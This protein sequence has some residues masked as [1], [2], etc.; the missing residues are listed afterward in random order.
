MDTFI[1]CPG[2]GGRGLGQRRPAGENLISFGCGPKRGADGKLLLALPLGDKKMPSIGA[3]DVQ[4]PPRDRFD[5][6][7]VIRGLGGVSPPS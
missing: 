5:M 7:R 4:G 6:R 3:E 2:R 1:P